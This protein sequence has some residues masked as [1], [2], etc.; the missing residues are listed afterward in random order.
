MICMPFMN[1]KKVR[2]DDIVSVMLIISI[3]LLALVF[4]VVAIISVIVYPMICLI[5][6][7]FSKINKGLKKGS[8]DYNSKAMS[9][10]FGSLGISFSIFILM[11]I[12]LSSNITPGIILSLLA[13]PLV[14]TGFAGICKGIMI[15]EYSE[16]LRTLNILTG[17]MTMF[18]SIFALFTSESFVI[19]HFI[20]LL[21]CLALNFFLRSALY[22]SEF[23]LSVRRLENFKV[24]FLIIN[25]Y[26]LKLDEYKVNN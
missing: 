14:I 23:G 8:Q 24:I 11:I 13:F 9:I 12:F 3:L 5:I 2:V 17:I 25:G 18:F 16:K 19:F 4:R 26:Y 10:I 6:H 15:K 22:L 7:G 20:T 1:Q 21:S